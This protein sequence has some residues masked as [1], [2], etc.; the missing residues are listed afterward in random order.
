MKKYNNSIVNAINNAFVE[1]EKRGWSK[2]YFF[3]DIHQT[4]LYPDYNNNDP[5]RFYKHAKVVLQFLSNHKD[6]EMGLYTC[7]YPNEIDNYLQFFKENNINF[8][9]INKNQDAKDTTYGYYQDKPY[10]NVLFEDKAGFDAETDWLEIKK[11]FNIKTIEDA[12]LERDWEMIHK[13]NS[14]LRGW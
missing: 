2:L 3:F 11:Y 5:K 1:K 9:H 7:S 6:I 14:I 13:I 8:L 12:K 10:Y 4:I